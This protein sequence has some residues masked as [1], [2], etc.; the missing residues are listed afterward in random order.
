MTLTLPAQIARRVANEAVYASWA[1]RRGVIGLD[2]PWV[3]A[4]IG[5]AMWRHGMLGGIPAIAALRHGR[6][7]AAIIDE[8]GTMTYGEL[9]DAANA[10]A[11]HWRT[12][13]L[14]PGDGISILARNHRWFLVATYAAARCGARIV[15]LNTDFAGPQIRDVAAREGTD[16]LV[17]DDEY[18][19]LLEGV[20]TRLG[21]LRAWTDDTSERGADS[22]A[23][24]VA[25]GDTTPAPRAGV[26]PKVVL[27]TSGTTG[28]PKGAP[29]AEPRS[30]APIGALLS[31]VPFE[32]KGTLVL[33]APMFHTL[34]FA[35]ALLNGSLGATLVVR[36]R[37]DPAL[38]L[39]DLSTHRATGMV[40]VPVMLQKMV[41][42]G[43]DAFAAA[44]LSRLTAI[45]VAGSQLGAELAVRSTSLFGP[46]LHNM[47]GSTEVAYATIAVPEDLAAEPGCVGQ[48]VM[49]AV[50]KIFG[51]DGT[52][53]PAGT[54]GRIFVGNDFQFEGYTGGGDKDRIDGLM[55]T[56]DV[57]HFDRRG[58]LFIDGRDDDMIVSGGENV[59]PGEIEE[60]LYTHDAV[61]EAAAIGVAD[62]RFGQRLRAFVVLNEGA[63]LSEDEVKAFVSSN[64]AR[65]KTPREV[66]FLDELPRNPTGKVLKRKLAELPTG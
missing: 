34:G 48:P 51:D 22:V 31:R 43:E 16:F 35:Q 28:T 27:L 25:R 17:H 57:G 2:P 5:R 14:R 61:R 11:N 32:A 66:V 39:E 64:L 46:V 41:E 12:A 26:D 38:V 47:Y 7:Q 53:V 36:R 3:V 23:G 33:P 1:Y 37:F 13:G 55:S 52:E 60:L 56:G 24:I 54:T 8:L 6:D 20:E 19:A 15:L 49:G 50:V 65:Y 42:L 45:F 62:E 10:L 4:Q 40:C 9:D 30:L 29:R 59:F 21:R 18:G 44:D 58:R 63:D